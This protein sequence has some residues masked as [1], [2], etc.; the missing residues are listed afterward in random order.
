MSTWMRSPRRILIPR[1]SAPALT[2]V[3]RAEVERRVDPIDGPLVVLGVDSLEEG[4]VH[5]ARCEPG[6]TS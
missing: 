1:G 2:F 5:Q 4:F 3:D 6:A